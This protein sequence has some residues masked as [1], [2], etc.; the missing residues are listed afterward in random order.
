[1]TTFNGN[2]SSKVL[3]TAFERANYKLNAFSNQDDQVVDFHFAEKTFY[4][5][6][7][8]QLDPVV[9][10]LEYLKS[11]DEGSSQVLNFVADQFY[12]MNTRYKN[13]LNLNL[14]SNQDAHLSELK[15]VKSWE[16]PTNAYK[17]MLDELMNEFLE[18]EVIPNEKTIGSFADFTALFRSYY[19]NNDNAAKITFSGFMKSK[20]SS[21]FH[22]GLAIQVAPVGFADDAA[23]ES[24]ILNSDNYKFFKNMARQFGFSINLQ[25][26]SIIISDLAHPV[27]TKFR[28]KYGLFNVSTV[29]DRQY[30]K[31]CIYDFDLLSQYLLSTYNS[32]IYLRPN[33]K[34]VYICNNKTKSNIYKRNN[35]SNIDYSNILLLY[36]NIRNMEE[37]F[38]FSDSEVISIHKTSVRLFSADPNKALKYIE[39][40]FRSRYNTKDG[41]LTYYKKKFQK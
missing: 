25:N 16:S 14:I 13:A 31:S 21:I 26:P 18:R 37:L 35:I 20:E 33:L 5:R 38:S 7:N 10:K 32:F 36:I 40:Q 39:S 9:P 12:E 15:I 24:Q 6:V 1:M 19:F 41:S 17:L 8:R 22:S 4:G 30:E 28:E 2:N 11:I 27:T 23:K 3:R 29:F 34:K